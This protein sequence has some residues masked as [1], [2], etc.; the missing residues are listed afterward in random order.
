MAREDIRAARCP[1]CGGS[2]SLRL[3][4]NGLTYLAM[5]CCKAQLF[6]RGPDSDE[7]L[8]ALPD[9]PGAPPATAAPAPAVLPLPPTPAKLPA[10]HPPN[11]KA[12]EPEPA[13]PRMGWG[14]FPNA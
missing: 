12:L 2:A 3:S 8:R 6:S 7:L 9:A 4:T 5:D 13:K 1:L 11:P 10:P 14:A